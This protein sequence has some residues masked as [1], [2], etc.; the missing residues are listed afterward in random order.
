MNG[1][2]WNQDLSKC[3]RV[4]PKLVQYLPTQILCM[5]TYQTY[6]STALKDCKELAKKLDHGNP[7]LNDLNGLMDE[8][9][10]VQ[11]LLMLLLG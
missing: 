2:S 11:L 1:L 10:D 5:Q 7:I 4:L 6:T 8:L 9:I 3:S